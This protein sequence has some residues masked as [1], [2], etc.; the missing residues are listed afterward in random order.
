VDHDRL[1]AHRRACRRGRAQ[2]GGQHHRGGAL[3]VVVERAAGAGVL[4]QDAA[5]VGGAEV[6]PVQHGVR[7]KPGGGADIG[8]DQLVIPFTPDP[9]VPAAQVHV[10]GQQVRVVGPG[11]QHDRDDPAGMQAGRRGVDGQ[12]PVR[13]RDAA[14]PPV[15]DAQ[16]A[17]GVGGDDQ[18][19]LVGPKTVVA[20]G[21][22]DLVGVIDRQVHPA[23]TAEVQA[24]PLD[25]GPHRRGVHDRQHLVDV[26]G[27]QPVEQHLVAVPH[28]AEMQALGQVIGLAQV[29]RVDP[30]QL[31]LDRRHAVGQQPGEPE[32]LP[33]GLRERGAPVQHRRREHRAAPQPDPRHYPLGCPGELKRTVGHH[34]TFGPG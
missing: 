13:D 23:R 5:G 10:L 14:H 29:L 9:R 1:I 25:H 6:L 26:L 8:V 3:D 24:V 22:L 18:V 27:Q 11:V 12:F 17:L 2:R 19:H 33:F 20:E 30:P 31:P 32:R 16:D 15:A 4:Q 21:R 7:E 28:L 34:T